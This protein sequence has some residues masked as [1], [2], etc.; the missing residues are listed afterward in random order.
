MRMVVFRRKSKEWGGGKELRVRLD[1]QFEGN[2]GMFQ[3]LTFREPYR[4]ICSY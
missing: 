4:E 3:I 2:E 1:I